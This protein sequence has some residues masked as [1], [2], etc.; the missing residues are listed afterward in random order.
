MDQLNVEISGTKRPRTGECVDSLSFS[1]RDD[2]DGDGDDDNSAGVEFYDIS[3]DDGEQGA[4]D[5]S[6]ASRAVTISIITRDE[7]SSEQ[8][9]ML[10]TLRE[11]TGQSLD[12]ALALAHSEKW[13]V[14]KITRKWHRSPEA[15]AE[16]LISAGICD[17]RT[18]PSAKE[19]TFMCATC[20]SER[21]AADGF[22]LACGHTT[23]VDCWSAGLEALTATPQCLKSTC[24]EAA[25]GV[26]VPASVFKR[27]LNPETFLEYQSW[28]L[29]MF[30]DC[31]ASKL[32]RCPNHRCNRIALRSVALDSITY[33]EVS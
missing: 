23:C 1:A 14:D 17:S 20:Y 6:Y 25:C 8:H 11:L 22:A 31:S 3:S 10:A 29:E 24:F 19:A 13:D 2:A 5:D 18:T 21:F 9:T 15:Q 33:S 28:S 7:V 12:V 16:L 30:I 27:F 32:R 4:D 26:V